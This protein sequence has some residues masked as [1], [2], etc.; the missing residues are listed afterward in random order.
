MKYC[1]IFPYDFII[2]AC[3]I[4]KI[5]P[6]VTEY[7]FFPV[8]C[9]HVF[10]EHSYVNLID[11]IRLDKRTLFCFSKISLRNPLKLDNQS[12]VIEIL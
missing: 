12:V 2:G 5:T 6:K 4:N 11:H 3:F 10:G 8:S 1:I 7:Y 9:E